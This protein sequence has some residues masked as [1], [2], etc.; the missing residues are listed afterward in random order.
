MKQMRS[1]IKG[2]RAN[3]Q[4]PNKGFKNH[5]DKIQFVRT[6]KLSQDDF[7]EFTNPA[8]LQEGMQHKGK[9]TFRDSSVGIKEQLERLNE[10]S[11]ED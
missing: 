8:D 7:S 3:I 4:Q 6:K 9:S 1:Q 11:I 5:S 10:G 2:A